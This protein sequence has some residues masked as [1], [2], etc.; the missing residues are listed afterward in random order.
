MPHA[1]RQPIR[2][3]YPQLIEVPSAARD[4]F[5]AEMC[6]DDANLRGEIAAHAGRPMKAIVKDHVFNRLFPEQYARV[7]DLVSRHADAQ[8][9][10]LSSYARE[11]AT[12]HASGATSVT[13]ALTDLYTRWSRPDEAVRWQLKLLPPAENRVYGEP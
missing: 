9:V 4:A 8:P 7:L 10:L 1:D 11:S 12:P 3:T 6:G 2:R 5:L 13:T